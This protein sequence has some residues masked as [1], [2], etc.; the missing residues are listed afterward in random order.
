MANVFQLTTNRFSD[1]VMVE[2]VPDSTKDFFVPDRIA[3]LSIQQ[4]PGY[5][6]LWSLKLASATAFYWNAV[7]LTIRF[8]TRSSTLNNTSLQS[9]S[10]RVF[11]TNNR[12]LSILFKT[13]HSSFNHNL[14]AFLRFSFVCY[15]FARV[16]KLP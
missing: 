8:L 13:S 10:T 3:S 7:V 2:N 4:N 12:V 15:F 5:C 9:P 1:I 14:K 6:G 16:R 11:L